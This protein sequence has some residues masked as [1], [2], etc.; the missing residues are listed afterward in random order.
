MSQIVKARAGSQVSALVISSYY[1]SRL[2]TTRRPMGTARKTRVNIR[3][4]CQVKEWLEFRWDH[5]ERR[6]NYVRSAIPG[7]PRLSFKLGP[8]VEP[9]P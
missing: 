4:G 2:R 7:V 3:S 1:I 9:N 5:C 6:Y 8:P